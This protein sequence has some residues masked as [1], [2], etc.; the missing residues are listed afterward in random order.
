MNDNS[1][2]YTAWGWWVESNKPPDQ[3]MPGLIADWTGKPING[4]V[5]IQNDLKN[6]PGRGIG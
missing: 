4:G 2:H 3:P 5:I 1:F 6:N